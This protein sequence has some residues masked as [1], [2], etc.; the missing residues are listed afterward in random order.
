M[1]VEIITDRRFLLK[2]V[3]KP[4]L[5]CSEILKENLVVIQNNIFN[6]KLNYPIY[7]G[8]SILDLSKLTIYEFYY[9]IK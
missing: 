1:N 5:K 2:R 9:D 4:S 6:L 7:V 8:F 3:A